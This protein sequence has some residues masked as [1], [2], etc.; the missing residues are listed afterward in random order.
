MS[1]YTVNNR[2]VLS[3]YD[4]LGLCKCDIKG[5]YVYSVIFQIAAEVLLKIWVFIYFFILLKSILDPIGRHNRSTEGCSKLKVRK[6]DK[7]R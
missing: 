6:H 5:I 4:R 3:I 2:I 7:R 1:S